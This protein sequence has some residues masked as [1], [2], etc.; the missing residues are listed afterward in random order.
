IGAIVRAEEHIPTTL[1][2]ESHDVLVSGE[3]K[4][5]VAKHTVKNVIDDAS[6][7]DY[8][9]GPEPVRPFYIDEVVSHGD[10]GERQKLEGLSRMSM[11]KVFVN[12][13]GGGYGTLEQLEDLDR[14]FKGW[15]RAFA[16]K[17]LRVRIYR[18]K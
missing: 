7:D 17:G 12:G 5:L 9:L 10:V 16:T 4:A 8:Q 11:D 18:R 15:D 2:C 3:Q 14:R 6:V 13:P 1:D